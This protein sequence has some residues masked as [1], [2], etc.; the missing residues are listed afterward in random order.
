VICCTDQTA[1]LISLTNGGA[2]IS[3][4]QTED[5]LKDGSGSGGPKGVLGAPI[6]VNN[7]AVIVGADEP[8]GICTGGAS[9]LTKLNARI[10]K[11]G[12]A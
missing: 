8:L 3:I 2:C 5:D 10:G 11:R 9:S 12:S 4:D 6:L 7:A 1:S